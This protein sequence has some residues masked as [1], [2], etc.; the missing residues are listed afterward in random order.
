MRGNAIQVEQNAEVTRSEVYA[1][2]PVNTSPALD[3][4]IAVDGETSAADL[5]AEPPGIGVSIIMVV[6]IA[7]LAAVAIVRRPD[8]PGGS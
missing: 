5:A 7:V 2:A 8:R 6:V 3:V 1:A 4:L